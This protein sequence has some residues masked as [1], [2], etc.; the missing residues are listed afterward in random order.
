M[1]SNSENGKRAEARKIYNA[2][3]EQLM[4]LGLF[5]KTYTSTPAIYNAEIYSITATFGGTVGKDGTIYRN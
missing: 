3:D 4:D 2:V 5:A 1:F